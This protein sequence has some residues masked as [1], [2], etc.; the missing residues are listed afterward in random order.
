MRKREESVDQEK[1][2]YAVGQMGRVVVMRLGP[3][4]DI[5]PA[6]VEIA[7]DCG[8]N[9]GIILGGAASLTHAQLRNVRKYPGEFPITDE[10]RIFSGF[11]GPLELLS[12]S[13]NIS[14]D[15]AGKPYIHCH[16]AVSTGQPDASAYGGHLLPGT[17]V[18]S[19]AELSL[20]EVLGC[21]ILRREDAETRVGEL[22]FRVWDGE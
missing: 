21:G 10:V 20:V 11:E 19:T 6:I 18:F 9:Q 5:L 7:N 2:R 22:Y 15:E 14:Q 13:G 3:G 16:A 1:R 12:L 8:I 17:T 4:D